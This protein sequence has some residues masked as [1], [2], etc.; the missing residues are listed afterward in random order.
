MAARLCLDMTEK[1]LKATL[2]QNKQNK[3]TSPQP[4]LNRWQ[5]LTQSHPLFCRNRCGASCLSSRAN[6][7]GHDARSSEQDLSSAFLSSLVFVKSHTFKSGGARWLSGS[8]SDSGARGRG[9]ETYRRRVVSFS[10]TLY[11]PKVLVNYPGSCGSV[12]T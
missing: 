4:D 2:N 12:P 3:Q 9:F 1:W 8:V 7:E 5:M 10:K 11:S 6:S